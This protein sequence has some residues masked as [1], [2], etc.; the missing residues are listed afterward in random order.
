MII[1]D[2]F[3]GYMLWEENIFEMNISD[4]YYFMSK[5]NIIILYGFFFLIKFFKVVVFY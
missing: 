4:F 2:Y 3:V 5:L 1:Y